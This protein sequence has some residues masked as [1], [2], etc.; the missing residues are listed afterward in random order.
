MELSNIKGLT[1]NDVLKMM[2]MKWTVDELNEY[3][4]QQQKLKNREYRKKYLSSEHGQ[5]A[6]KRT[7]RKYSDKRNVDNIMNDKQLLNLILQRV[8]EVN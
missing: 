5:N 8:N 6:L 7:Q 1:K 3:K 2:E 4:I